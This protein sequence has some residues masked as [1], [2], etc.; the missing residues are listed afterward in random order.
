MDEELSLLQRKAIEVPIN[1][2]WRKKE[3]E[4]EPKGTR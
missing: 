2:K 4:Q 3:M 1:E